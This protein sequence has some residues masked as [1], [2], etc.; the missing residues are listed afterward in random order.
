MAFII[1]NMDGKNLLSFLS[2]HFSE[3]ELLR[4]EIS[5]ALQIS[6]N[7]PKLVLDAVENLYDSYL[8]DEELKSCVFLLELLEGLSPDIIMPDVKEAAQNVAFNWEAKLKAR[9]RN[10]QL[11]S[12]YLLLISA[13]KLDFTLH[14]DEL[15]NF[16]ETIAEQEP[17]IALPQAVG[18]FKDVSS[19]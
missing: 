6:Y 13:Y 11:T 17:S 15:L 2:S 8:T 12:A 19:K 1:A 10:Y 18:I 14:R 16:Y 4:D 9:N 3:H 7:S 5:S